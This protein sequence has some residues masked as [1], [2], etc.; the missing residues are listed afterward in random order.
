MIPKF[1]IAKGQFINET[2]SLTATRK[3]MKSHLSKHVQDLYNL[4]IQYNDLK[5]LLSSNSGIEL[6]NRRNNNARRNYENVVI[7]LLKQK[8]KT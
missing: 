8:F 6:G 2:D 7:Y 5:L 1:P 3:L 4:S